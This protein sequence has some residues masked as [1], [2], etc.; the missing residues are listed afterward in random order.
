MFIRERLNV[1]KTMW[2]NAYGISPWYCPTSLEKKACTEGPFATETCL[3]K[4]ATNLF[5]YMEHARILR[6]L[7]I[8]LRKK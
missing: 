4:K 1:Y 3:V 5:Y 2:C 8:L 6:L 7:L